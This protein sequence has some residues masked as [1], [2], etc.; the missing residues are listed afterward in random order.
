MSAAASRRSEHERTDERRDGS[1][2]RCVVAVAGAAGPP[3]AR[4]LLRLRRGRAHG[5][6]LG[7]DADAARG[8]RGRGAAAHRHRRTTVDLLDLDATR[9]WADRTEKEFGRVD[10]L[11]HLVGGWRGAQDLRRRPTRRLGLPA[12]S[13]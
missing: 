12:R 5:R 4:R 1:A 9:A 11:V 3:G 7:S 2:G 13:C 10:G 6:R 8:G